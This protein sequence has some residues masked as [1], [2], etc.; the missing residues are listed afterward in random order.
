MHLYTP[1]QFHIGIQASHWFRKQ[2]IKIHKQN[3]HDSVQIILQ[4]SIPNE[5]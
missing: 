2:E 3:N 1:N 5:L 4:V